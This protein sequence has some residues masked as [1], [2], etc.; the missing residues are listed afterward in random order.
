MKFAMCNEFCVDW[1][2]ED[3]FKLAREAGY[4]GMEI[5]PFTI[6][7]SVL[8]ITPAQRADIRR[9]AERYGVAIIGLHWL[10]VKPA[11][12][13]LNCPDAAIRRQ[14]RDYFEALIHCCAD[15]GGDRLVIGSPKNRNIMPGVT[16]QEAWDYSL[17]TFASLLAPARDR[18]V[19]LCLEPLT[20]KETNFITSVNEGVRMCKE[21]NHPN[22]LVHIDVKAMTG[23]KRPLD[24]VIRDGKGYVGHFH[25]NDEN[26]NGPGWGETDYEPV[27]R[28]VKAIGYDDYASVEV[29]NF[30]F[31]PAEIAKKSIEFLRK[32]FV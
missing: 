7:E 9:M 24:D 28:G 31:P 13:Y 19:K 22:F 14:T 6:A 18:G 2:L 3:C 26:L 5:A 27:V 23:E 20:T 8:D 11:G 15:F 17:E 16:Y 25:V 1:P 32:V 21:L 4:D 30:T 29:F 12:L 10:L